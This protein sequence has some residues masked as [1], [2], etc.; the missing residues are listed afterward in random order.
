MFQLQISEYKIL[1]P[2]ILRKD[3]GLMQNE[4][5]PLK[6]CRKKAFIHLYFVINLS[7]GGRNYIARV[8]RHTAIR[9]SSSLDKSH[10]FPWLTPQKIFFCQDEGDNS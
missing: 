3:E 4:R 2:T 10:H 8:L 1:L 6:R 9:I 7:I 5:I